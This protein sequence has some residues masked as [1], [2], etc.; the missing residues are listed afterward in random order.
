MLAAHR[1]I[2]YPIV[3]RRRRHVDVCP[4][5]LPLPSGPDT[6]TDLDR[7]RRWCCKSGCDWARIGWTNPY[8]RSAVW[9]FGP[10]SRQAGK[11]SFR[12][13]FFH[14]PP[15][16]DLIISGE[17]VAPTTLRLFGSSSLRTSSTPTA[18]SFFCAMPTSQ[19]AIQ[20]HCAV[21]AGLTLRS[22]KMT[23]QTALVGAALAD[24]EAPCAGPARAAQASGIRH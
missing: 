23:A 21:A 2:W 4:D 24:L 6:T 22:W 11:P 5:F 1:G 14:K 7:V 13:L 12:R 17:P 10:R 20:Y 18:T 19:H 15:C 3:W 9:R 16:F 8:Q